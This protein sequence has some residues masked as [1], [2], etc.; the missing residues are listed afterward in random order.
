MVN[1]LPVKEGDTRCWFNPWVGK[2]PWNRKWQLLQ[3]SCLGKP[4]DRGARWATVHGVARVKT[5]LSTHTHK[6]TLD[7]SV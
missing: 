2:I 7:S 3:Y 4:M 5:Q 6:V 1:S